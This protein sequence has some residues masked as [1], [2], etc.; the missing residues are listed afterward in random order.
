MDVFA[1]RW[2]SFS[3]LVDCLNGLPLAPD[4]YSV[5]SFSS[6]VLNIITLLSCQSITSKNWVRLLGNQPVRLFYTT[7]SAHNESHPI[8]SGLVPSRM[9]PTK[10]R[11][12]SLK[13]SK[14]FSRDIS[15][16][17]KSCFWL[18]VE[19][20]SGR[21]RGNRKLIGKCGRRS[22]G[23]CCRILLDQSVRTPV[24][25]Q[26]YYY[27]CVY[28]LLSFFWFGSVINLSKSSNCHMKYLL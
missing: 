10:L 27:V 22:K 18:I 26:L 8:S 23:L 17:P 15:L 19:L 21:W 11:I 12:I 14:E 1:L 16:L 13:Q 28:V 25:R 9:L 20:S 7:P 4:R 24:W 5:T 6:A 2:K 3:L